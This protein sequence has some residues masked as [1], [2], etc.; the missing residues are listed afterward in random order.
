MENNRL[1]RRRHSW[2]LD[3]VAHYELVLAVSSTRAAVEMIA[4]VH[5]LSS[6]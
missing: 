5:R 2:A 4:H 1:L 3:T 6:Q